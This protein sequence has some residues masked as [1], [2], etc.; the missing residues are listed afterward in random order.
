MA[1]IFVS[2][3]REDR[4][5][6]ASFS[7]RLHESTGLEVWWDRSILPGEQF[8]EA[9]QR[10]LDGVACVIVVW[11]KNS[12]ASRWVKTEAREAA[13]REILVPVMIEDVSLPLEF[14]SFQTADLSSWRGDLDDANFRELAEAVRAAIQ[15]ARQPQ[16]RPASSASAPPG[17]PLETHRDTARPRASAPSP[18]RRR[19]YWAAAAVLVILGATTVLVKNGSSILG[20]STQS[21]QAPHLAF[22]TWT[23]RNA[24]DDQGNNWSNSALKFTSEEET[25]DG[26]VLLGTFTWRRENALVGTEEFKGH[27]IAATRQI[28]FEGT[29]VTDIPHPG[30]RILAVGSYSAVLS[31]DGR[32]IA[33]GRWGVTQLKDDAGV[34]GRWEAVR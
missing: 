2:Y 1:D 8:D 4:D 27:Y 18:A 10:A 31:M 21:K 5:W 24:V 12:V 33:D 34:L 15:R 32:T 19:Y 30:E 17:Q 22:G 26:M 25:P 16:D 3:A 11:S 14:R 7:E 28:F 13:G 6:V 9:I 23:L 29:A 20:R